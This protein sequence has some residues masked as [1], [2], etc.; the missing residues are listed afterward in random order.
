M[1]N[2]LRPQEKFV[3]RTSGALRQESSINW[4]P[5]QHSMNSEFLLGID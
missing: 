3:L 5:L 4:I 2:Q 1:A